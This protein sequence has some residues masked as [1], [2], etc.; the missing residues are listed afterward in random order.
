VDVIKIEIKFMKYTLLLMTCIFVQ[1]C[2]KSIKTIKVSENY[3]YGIKISD[4]SD[5]NI[6]TFPM[7]G[8]CIKLDINSKN[9]NKPIKYP[10]YNFEIE[11][12]INLFNVLNS[13][14]TGKENLFIKS[15]ESKHG[16]YG[17]ARLNKY[18]TEITLEVAHKCEK[19]INVYSSFKKSSI[20]KHGKL[21]SLGVISENNSQALIAATIFLSFYEALSEI[22]NKINKDC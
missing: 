12:V 19:G 15:Y 7:G 1:S 11:D 14:K 2:S 10:Y 17:R 9:N 5:L 20:E 22:I 13:C 6:G 18:T 3:Q 8:F 16:Y 4:T 21:I